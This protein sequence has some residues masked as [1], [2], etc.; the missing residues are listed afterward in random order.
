MANKTK[1]LALKIDEETK[2]A[3]ESICKENHSTPSHELRLFVHQYIKR[4]KGNR[5][6]LSDLRK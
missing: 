1:I 2:E 5:I 3:F 4:N 6:L